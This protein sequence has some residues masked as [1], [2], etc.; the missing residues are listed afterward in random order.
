MLSTT[1]SS[2]PPVDATAHPA[3]WKPSLDAA[4][5]GYNAFAERNQPR[6][7]RYAQARLVRGADVTAAVRATLSLARQRWDWLLLQPSLA[8]DVWAELRRQVSRQ[9]DEVVPQDVTDAAALYSSL[10]V[11]SADSALLCWRVGL[12]A[13]EAAELMGLE[14]PAVEASLRVARRVHPHLAKRGAL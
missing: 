6:Y 7:A 1:R 4:L 12:T 2:V 5:L 9:A 14:Q 8:A 13:S 11:T 3:M 10:P